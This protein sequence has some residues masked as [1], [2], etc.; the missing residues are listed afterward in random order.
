MIVYTTQRGFE[1]IDGV[2]VCENGLYRDVRLLQQSSA[3]RGYDDAIERPGSSCLWVGDV[4][5]NREE[6][7]D[8][9]RHLQAWLDTGSLVVPDQPQAEDK[10]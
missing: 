6:V 10:P 7:R 4:S 9:V 1:R 3:I 2:A 8:L 5:L